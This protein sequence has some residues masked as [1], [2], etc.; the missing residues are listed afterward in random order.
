MSQFLTA[1]SM[2]AKGKKRI[3]LIATS[4]MK[5]E[6]RSRILRK[7]GLEV[8]CAADIT[9]ARS[10]WRADFYSLVLL[11]IGNDSLRV[12]EFCTE[13]KAAKPSQRMAF[14]VGKPE[15]LSASSIPDDLLVIPEEPASPWGTM[16]AALHANGSEKSPPRWGFQEATWQIAA[17]R[18]LK[19]PRGN[20]AR[21]NGKGPRL[22]WTDAVN[23][24]SR[25]PAIE[26][27][28]QPDSQHKEI[29]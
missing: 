20:L 14:L 28:P 1:V 18:S 10:L 2:L 7:L 19:D 6:L 23:Y 21:S 15:Y 5:R 9:E 16:V 13:I 8:D 11:D 22:S 4:A 25:P 26:T 24:H 12:A 27:A 29:S 17:I 3:L